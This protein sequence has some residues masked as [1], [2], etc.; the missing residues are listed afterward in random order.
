MRKSFYT[1]PKQRPLNP[2]PEAAN[3][4][5][6]KRVLPHTVL[7]NFCIPLSPQGDDAAP[8]AIRESLNLELEFGRE[9]FKERIEQMTTRQTRLGKAG[10]LPTPLGVAE[11]ADGY[12]M[13]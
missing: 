7:L 9:D 3:Q 8:R 11:P 13:M 12:Y 1:G 2:N 6:W 4:I 5:Y 10:R